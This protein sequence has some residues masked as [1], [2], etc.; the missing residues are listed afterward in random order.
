VTTGVT[1][2]LFGD[3]DL[4]TKFGDRRQRTLRTGE[5][6]DDMIKQLVSRCSPRAAWTS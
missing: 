5:I 2:I 4:S 6:N 3:L 1:G